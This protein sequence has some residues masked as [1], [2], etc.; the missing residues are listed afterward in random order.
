MSDRIGEKQ[1][2]IM[3]LIDQQIKGALKD[4]ASRLEILQDRIK[5]AI[6]IGT[7]EPVSYT[8]LTLPTIYS[9]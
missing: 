3:N 1:E 5:D 2:T 8:H 6:D 7:T 4:Q 9:V